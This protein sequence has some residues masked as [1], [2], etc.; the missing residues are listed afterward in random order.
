MEQPA[1]LA[2]F[3]LADRDEWPSER[4]R[5][6]ME[7][8]GTERAVFLKKPVPVHLQYWT[9]WADEEGTTHFRNDVYQR[10]NAVYRA[11]TKETD[12]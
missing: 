7:T 10:D 4:I 6:A 5:T 2:A 12:T 3:L 1:A 11:L 8:G 9:A